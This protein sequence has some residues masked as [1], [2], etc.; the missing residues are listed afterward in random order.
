MNVI[1]R[2]ITR[3]ILDHMVEK[4]YANTQSEAIRLA[5]IN[6][7]KEHFDEIAMVNNKLD[8]IDNEIKSGKS[9][10]LNVDEALGKY[11]KNLKAIKK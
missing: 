6:F 9:K 10:L 5:I 11:S 4:G 3:T 2:G 7:G 1:L 8:L